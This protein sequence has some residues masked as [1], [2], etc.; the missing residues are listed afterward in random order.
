MCVCLQLGNEKD[1]HVACKISIG[2][3]SANQNNQRKEDQLFGQL[4]T[5]EGFTCVQS[6]SRNMVCRDCDFQSCL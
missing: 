6:L 3:A 5:Y 1:L 4:L 2:Y